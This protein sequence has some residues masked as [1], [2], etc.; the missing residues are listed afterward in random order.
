MSE[1]TQHDDDRRSGGT[2]D[3][4]PSEPPAAPARRTRAEQQADTRRRLLDAAAE[5]ISEHGFDG[6]PIDEICQR[7]G[8]TRGA[9]YSNFSDKTDLLVTLC[10]RRLTSFADTELPA[11]LQV[12]EAEQLGAIAR[13]LADEPLPIE[14]L[15]LVELARQRRV[16]EESAASVDRVLTTVLARLQELMTI[17]DSKLAG[18]PTEEVAVRARAVLAAV[19]GAD[20]LGHLGVPKEPRMI[21]LLLSG[22][23]AAPQA[24]PQDDDDPA[25]HD[26]EGR[27]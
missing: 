20:L 18:L 5:V 19:L 7:A 23:D 11:I 22:I 25:Q 17:E 2:G 16:N 1:S 12:P 26:V 13:W 3:P 14:V 15:L 10:D 27:P 9:F 4:A 24:L 21:E 6:A 8:Y